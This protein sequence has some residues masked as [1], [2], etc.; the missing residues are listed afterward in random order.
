MAAFETP[1]AGV[2]AAIEM[3]E[4]LA[5]FNKNISHALNLKI[6]VH[7]GRS[8]AVTLN[9][10]IDYFGQNVNIATRIQTLADANEVYI[11]R[12]VMD[13]PGVR[14]ILKAHSVEADHVNVKGVSEK[15]EVYR[16]TVS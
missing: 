11:S 6:G 10:R 7:Q 9:D 5:A 3:I 12:E 2:A 1:Q 4:E 8:F 15:L 16:V 13:A 14:D